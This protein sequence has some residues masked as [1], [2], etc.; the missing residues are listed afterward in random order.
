MKRKLLAIVAAAVLSLSVVGVAFADPTDPPGD[1]TEPV[2]TR[3]VYDGTIT[4]TATTKLEK[5][6]VVDSDA[7]V[8]AATFTYS[9]R[10]GQASDSADATHLPVYS[11]P[12]APSIGNATFTAGQSATAENATAVGETGRIGAKSEI[13]V[14]FSSVP[15]DAPGVYRYVVTEN[16]VAGPFAKL[17]GWDELTLD[18]YVINDPTTAGALKID[19]YVAYKGVVTGNPLN[20]GGATPIEG[21]TKSKLFGNEVETDDLTVKKVIAGNQGNLDDKFE[22]TIALNIGQGNQVKVDGQAYTANAQGIATVTATL[23]HNETVVITGIPTSSVTYTITETE[24]NTNGYTTEGQVTDKAFTGATTET[25]T[26]TRNGA[27]PTGV[28][29]YAIPGLVLVALAVVV[30]ARRRF[31]K[32]S[33]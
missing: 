24:A 31:S 29:T 10:G 25:I 18:V 17:T 22:F 32:A 19:G 1:N 4:G 16:A 13:E 2:A 9:I 30:L 23:G 7:A 6:L 15:F 21:Q 33:R 12:G 28:L 11:G 3:S 8:P 27:V 14:D 20:T 5:V 26:N